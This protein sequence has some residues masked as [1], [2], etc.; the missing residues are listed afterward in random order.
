M[1]ID[2]TYDKTTIFIDNISYNN[3]LTGIYEFSFVK[4]RN[5]LNVVHFYWPYLKIKF[6]IYSYFDLTTLQKILFVKTSCN[7]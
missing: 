2:L 3:A 5:S 4:F 7:K 6:F 1:T